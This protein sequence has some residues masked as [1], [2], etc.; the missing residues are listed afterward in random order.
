MDLL[1]IIIIYSK[2]WDYL[3]IYKFNKFLTNTYTFVDVDVVL[4]HKA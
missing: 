1:E 3:N 2:S 4:V